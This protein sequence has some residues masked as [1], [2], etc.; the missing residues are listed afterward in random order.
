MQMLTAFAVVVIAALIAI[1]LSIPNHVFSE[2]AMA[3]ISRKAIATGAGN[4][5]LVVESVVSQL[6][7]RY[8]EWII[9]KPE[10]VFN[11]AGGAMGSMLVLHASL[12]EYV[13]IFG[14]AIGTEGHTGR[15]LADD[16]FTILVGEQVATNSNT[17]HFILYSTNSV[18]EHRL[19]LQYICLCY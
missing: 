19:V 7:A 8:P 17:I 18:F 11:N 3:E 10:W 12:S 13:I 1:P 2:R 9:E 6:R 16:W 14:S 15:F 5:S 4:S